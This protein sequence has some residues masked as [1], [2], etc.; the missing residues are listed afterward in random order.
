MLFLDVDGV[1]NS[2]AWMLRIATGEEPSSG[3]TWTVDPYPAGLIAG[4]LDSTGA[5]VVLSSGWRDYPEHLPK[6]TGLG[7]AIWDMTAS[8]R[9]RHRHAPPRRCDQ[10]AA[11][12]AEHPEVTQFAIVDDDEDAGLLH[13][14]RFVRT[15]WA[16]GLTRERAEALAALLR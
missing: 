1:L 5:R 6:I 13:P 3:W 11:W 10:I 8:H 16:E 4:V 12:L 7:I 14:D 15:L 9:G 2:S